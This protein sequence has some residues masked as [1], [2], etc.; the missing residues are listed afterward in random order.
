MAAGSF[1]ALGGGGAEVRE[2]LFRG[3]LLAAARDGTTPRIVF[4]QAG[5]L[6]A[7]RADVSARYRQLPLPGL[8]DSSAD[9]LPGYQ[10]SVLV[11]LF[12][13]QRQESGTRT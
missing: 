4:S 2:G 1:G 10:N 5:M 7:L 12:W 3:G 8:A 11:G 6:H 13:R 9:R